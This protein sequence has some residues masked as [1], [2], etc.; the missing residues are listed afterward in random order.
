TSGSHI[1]T[2]MILVIIDHPQL[3]AQL[4]LALLGFICEQREC[5]ELFWIDLTLLSLEPT[6]VPSL[7]IWD[8]RCDEQGGR[9]LVS[10]RTWLRVVRSRFRVFAN[11][12]SMTLGRKLLPV[13]RDSPL[14]HMHMPPVP[15][16]R[17]STG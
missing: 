11:I 17:S 2:L 6:V 8:S 1:S 10:S 9:M 7:E 3:L 5:S 16:A 12:P 13:A 15:V 14:E 4:S